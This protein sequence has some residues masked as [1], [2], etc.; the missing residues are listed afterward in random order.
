MDPIPIRL[1]KGVFKND[2]DGFSLV[3]GFA[4]D[5]RNISSQYFPALSLRPGFSMLGSS[6]GGR[7]TGL[8]VWQN[9]EL[10]GIA[11]GVWNKLV[12]AAWSGVSGGTG[13]S[14]TA[15]CSFAN[16]RG[17]LSADNLIMA[18]G[19]DPIK[20]Y[21]GSIVQNLANAPANGNFI[22]Q[23]DNRLDRKSVV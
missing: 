19:I 2:D 5:M 1:F 13:L 7:T 3:E 9:Q 14:L 8:G 6:L 20:R 17:N 10:H 16:F 18:N 22:E 4:Q 11:N 21:D 12:G 15:D 23:H